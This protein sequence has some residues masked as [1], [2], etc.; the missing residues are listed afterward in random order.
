VSSAPPRGTGRGHGCVEVG[1]E[2][3]EGRRRGRRKGPDDEQRPGRE[4]REVR[5]DQVAQTPPNPV[6]DHGVAHGFRHDEAGACRGGRRRLIELQVD[7]YGAP[8]GSSAAANHCGE[9]SATPQSLRRGQH[10]Y[11]GIRPDQRRLGRQLAAAFGAAGRQDRTAGTGAHAQPEA[12]GLRTTA[13]VRLEG[14]LAHVKTPSSNYVGGGI[15]CRTQLYQS[16]AEQPLDPTQGRRE[17]QQPGRS[18]RRQRS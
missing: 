13:V 4:F 10:D 9:V 5:P 18:A 11:L 3:R 12:V 1:A 15:G 7:D 17:G 8:A 2:R 6:T 14:A 16:A